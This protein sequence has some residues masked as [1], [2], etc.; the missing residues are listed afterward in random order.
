M[1]EESGAGVKL[2]GVNGKPLANG[3]EWRGSGWSVLVY[4]LN[5]RPGFTYPAWV[6]QLSFARYQLASVG[7]TCTSARGARDALVRAVNRLGLRVGKAGR[8][9]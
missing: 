5:D 1:G 8:R 3:Y 7:R 6:W 4:D 2:W 9:G